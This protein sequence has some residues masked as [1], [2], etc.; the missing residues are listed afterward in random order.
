MLLIAVVVIVVVV[1]VTLE[2]VEPKVHW[3]GLT[4]GNL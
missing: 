3:E 1:N 4:W 2:L